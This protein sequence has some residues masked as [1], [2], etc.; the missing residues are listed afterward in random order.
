MQYNLLGK[1]RKCISIFKK[2]K[3]SLEPGDCYSCCTN[4]D[5]AAAA[6]GGSGGGDGPL[7]KPPDNNNNIIKKSNMM[8]IKG[9]IN[10]LQGQV[11][12]YLAL[13]RV[14][15]YVFCDRG[16]GA[17]KGG[18]GIRGKYVRI[19]FGHDAI[20][21]ALCGLE[22]YFMSSCRDYKKKLEGIVNCI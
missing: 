5:D 7:S 20:D 11:H 21:G 13:V 22:C 17:S 1:E 10:R 4:D 2:S 8:M 19:Y 18:F 12:I 3:F 14:M 6:V 16:L 15:G 9:D